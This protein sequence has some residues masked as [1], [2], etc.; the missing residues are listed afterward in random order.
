MSAA[1]RSVLI[2]L[3]DSGPEGVPLSQIPASCMTTINALLTCGAVRKSRS[4][5]GTK[6]TVVATEAFERFCVAQFP[7]GLDLSDDI[8]EDRA[9]AVLLR[10]DAKAVRR[11]RGEGVLVRAVKPGITVDD[12]IKHAPVEVTT[13]TAASGAA[14]LLLDDEHRWSFA[15]T[16][17]LI[18]NAEAFWRYERVLPDID[19]GVYSPGMASNRLSAWLASDLMKNCSYIHWGDYDPV[20]TCEYQIGRAHV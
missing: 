6:V 20:D 16:A 10:G 7:L 5:R 8:P 3:R 15:G 2:R 14:A 19:L 12:A 18:K 4:G 11:G 17:A 13:L 1:D 9:E